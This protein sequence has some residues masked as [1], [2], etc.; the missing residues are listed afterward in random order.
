MEKRLDGWPM[1]FF[2]NSVEA[3]AVGISGV[4]A[5]SDSRSLK[6][7]SPKEHV[8]PIRMQA[9]GAGTSRVPFQ[10]LLTLILFSLRP[11]CTRPSFGVSSPHVS[12]CYGI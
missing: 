8:C 12:S 3:E 7:K 10:V 4:N 9:A 2:V 1:R 11:A 5:K 6:N